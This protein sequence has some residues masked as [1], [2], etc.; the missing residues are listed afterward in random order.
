MSVQ[1]SFPLSRRGFLAGAC[2]A[3][4]A[5]LLTPV[6]FAAMPG[7]NRFVT[8]ILRGAMDGLDFVQPYG[9]P[10]YAALRP[11]LGLRPDTGLIDLD[12][13]FGLNPAASALVPLWQA[14][15]L[16]FVHAVST[17]YRD[18]R[19]HFDGQDMLETG[20]NAKGQRTGWLNRTLAVIP[21]SNGRKAIDINTSMELILSGPNEADSWSSQSNF[22]LAEDEIA[23]LD[24]LYAGD[25]AFAKA[26]EEAKKTDMSA[27]SL[28][29]DNRRGAGIADMARLAGGMLREDY[30]IASFSINGWDTHVGQQGQFR[31]AVGDL[32][33]AIITLKDALGDEAWKKTVVL[34]M[35]EFGRTAR[36]NGTNGTDHGTGGLAVLAGGAIPGGRVLG[37]WPGLSEDKLLDRRDLMPTGDVREVAAAML[38]RQFGIEPDNLTTKVF[39]GLSFDRSSAYLRG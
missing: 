7:D 21:R 37:K 14:R 13:F 18:Q 10:A 9:D 17:P 2:C 36:E 8:I 6:S 33:T 27:D 15:E 20:G 34:A 12:G 1:D 38:Y 24:R 23:F 25:P 28:Y 22:A 19:S 11:K 35:T 31:K 5:P 3:A 30:R 39:P 16:S 29:A 26:M 32:S 4:A